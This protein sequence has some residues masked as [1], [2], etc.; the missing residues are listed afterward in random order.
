M[1]GKYPELIVRIILGD[2][3]RAFCHWSCSKRHL[4]SDWQL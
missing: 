4:L 3:A 1:N 2:Q